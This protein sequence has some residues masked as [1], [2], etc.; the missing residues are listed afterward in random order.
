MQ[1]GHGACGGGGAR[2]PTPTHGDRQAP[3]ARSLTC[4]SVAQAK[5]LARCDSFP[6]G[7]MGCG[8]GC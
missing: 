3:W 4:V 2:A 1:A 6:S 8:L 5:R 7:R